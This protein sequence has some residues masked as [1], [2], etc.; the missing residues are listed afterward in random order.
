MSRGGC[1]TH[2][3]TIAGTL[4]SR[5]LDRAG[6]CCIVG[7][8]IEELDRSKGGSGI[9]SSARGIV[10]EGGGKGRRIAGISIRMVGMTLIRETS[11]SGSKLLERSRAARRRRGKTR[12][13]WVWIGTGVSGCMVVLTTR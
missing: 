8:G 2:V 12:R 6:G 7:D 11:G 10:G 3:R 4:R 9:S 1:G 5:G 13:A